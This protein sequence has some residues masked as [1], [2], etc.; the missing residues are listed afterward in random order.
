M[1]P[2]LTEPDEELR[3]RLEYRADNLMDAAEYILSC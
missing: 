3:K 1:I 2:D